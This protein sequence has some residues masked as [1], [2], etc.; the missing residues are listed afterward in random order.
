MLEY[1]FSVYQLYSPVKAGDL[2][3]VDVPVRLGGRDTVSAVSGGTSG[4]LMKKG[5]QAGVALEAAL[6]ERVT[7]PVK[8]GDVLGEIRVKRGEEVLQVLPAVAGEDVAL[9][10]MIDSLIRIRDRFMLRH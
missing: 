5:D 7:A 1:G 2:L 9:P 8:K 6:V 10:G 4:L 3:G